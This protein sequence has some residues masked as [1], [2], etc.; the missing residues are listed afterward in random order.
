[1]FKTDRLGLAPVQYP[2]LGTRIVLFGCGKLMF[3]TDRLGLAPV[4]YPWLGTRIVRAES[5]QRA[6]RATIT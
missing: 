5:E 2:W 1:M 4:Q 3:K 6:S